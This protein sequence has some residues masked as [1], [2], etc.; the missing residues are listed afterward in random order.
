MAGLG[1]I[2]PPLPGVIRA[3][4]SLGPGCQA[5]EASAASVALDRA[6]RVALFAGGRDIADDA[7]LADVA[8]GVPDLRVEMVRS[9]VASGRPAAELERHAELAESTL[10]PASPTIVLSDGSAW[11]NPGIEFHTDD[12]VPSVDRDNA[13]VYGEIIDAFLAQRHYD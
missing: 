13:D 3:G 10:V 9:E 11:T 5:G 6:L 8:T 2:G 4:C 1:R 12:G 7:V